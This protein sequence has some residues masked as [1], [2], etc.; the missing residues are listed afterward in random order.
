MKYSATEIIVRNGIIDK[1]ELFNEKTGE[2]HVFSSLL[3]SVLQKKTSVN[4]IHYYPI[5]QL[6]DM[7]KIT[8]TKL[9][10]RAKFASVEALINV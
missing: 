9:L 8:I 1:V 10:E 3:S 2:T 7:D 4:N 5:E 6:S